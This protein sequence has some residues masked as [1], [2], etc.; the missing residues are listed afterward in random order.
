MN[1]RRSRGPHRRRRSGG[2]G[3]CVG[4]IVEDARVTIVDDNPN[5]GGQIWR[6]ELGKTRSHCRRLQLIESLDAGKRQLINNAAVRR[7]SIADSD[8]LLEFA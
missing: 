8:Y 2:A 4:R 5:V 1:K 3:R 6:A 7:H